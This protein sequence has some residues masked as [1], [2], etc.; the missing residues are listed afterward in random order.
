MHPRMII[1]AYNKALQD[2]LGTPHHRFDHFLVCLLA[3]LFET[4]IIIMGFFSFAIYCFSRLAH[5]QTIARPV[6][7]KNDAEMLNLVKSCLGTSMPLAGYLFCCSHL[8]PC[9]TPQS[10]CRAL[11]IRWR[12]LP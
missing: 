3:C 12:S 9:L 2:A 6:D 5:L 4:F 10:L 8:V 1:G 7:I 11:A